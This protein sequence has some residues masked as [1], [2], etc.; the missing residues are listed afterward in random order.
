MGNEQ[1]GSAAARGERK[2]PRAR[3]ASF[4]HLSC[5]D[6]LE[7]RHDMRAHGVETV[8][9]KKVAPELTPGRREVGHM[10]A[11]FAQALT[12]GDGR[13]VAGM[14]EVP[15]LLISDSGTR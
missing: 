15:A 13:A 2:L 12:L 1:L 5:N 6:F 10:L 8:E 3:W 14:W 9:R 4:G 11:A 7:R